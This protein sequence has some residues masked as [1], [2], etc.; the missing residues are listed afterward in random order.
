VYRV[1]RWTLYG[2]VEDADLIGCIG[3]ESL[4]NAAVIRSLVVVERHRRSGVGRKMV[5]AA[6]A[7]IDAPWVEAETDSDAVGF[8][9][10]LGFTATTLGEKYPGVERFRCIRASFR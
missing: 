4:S 8:Y 2:W 1:G 6:L 5:E 7:K 3:F 9:R 10:S